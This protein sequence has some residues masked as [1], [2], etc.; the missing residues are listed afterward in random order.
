VNQQSAERQ[1]LS[2][3]ESREH[4]R[5]FEVTHGLSF[6]ECA[7]QRSR[8]GG[9]LALPCDKMTDMRDETLLQ[10]RVMFERLHELQFQRKLAISR[11]LGL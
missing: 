5:A 11:A 6:C 2:A 3:D 7:G 10:V 8:G 4:G 1:R 9:E